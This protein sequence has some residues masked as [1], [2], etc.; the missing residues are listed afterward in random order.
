MTPKETRA[1]IPVVDV[2]VSITREEKEGR[3]NA[4][5]ERLFGMGVKIRIKEHIGEDKMQPAEKAM[6]M[7]V[8]DSIIIAMPLIHKRLSKEGLAETDYA[9]IKVERQKKLGVQADELQD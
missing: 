8:R 3:V 5:G 6:A 1:A 4:D 7:A 9:V 2:V